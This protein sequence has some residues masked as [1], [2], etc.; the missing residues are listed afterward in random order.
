MKSVLIHMASLLASTK[1]LYSDFVEERKIHDCFL[2]A[3]VIGV[4]ISYTE[5]EGPRGFSLIK[6]SFPVDIAIVG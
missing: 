1:D 6:V 5:D 3:Q 4:Y 2:V